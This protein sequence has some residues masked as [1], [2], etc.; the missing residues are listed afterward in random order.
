MIRLFAAIAVP[1]E[2]G[3]GLARRQQGLP[4]ARWRPN[5]ALHITLR[6]AG[7][8]AESRADDLDVELAAV[9]GEALTL[10]LEGVGSFDDGGEPHAV[11]AGVAENA[12]M[13]RLAARCETAARRAGLPAD[14]R[15]WRPHVTLAYLRRADPVRVAAWVQGHNLLKSPPFTATSFGL[16]SSHLGGEGAVYRLE[17]SYPLV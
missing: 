16:Y 3:A 17:R 7:E 14:R 5:Q 13:R 8:I 9:G 6:F 15:A 11:W 4:G 2:I 10:A 12:A 1:A